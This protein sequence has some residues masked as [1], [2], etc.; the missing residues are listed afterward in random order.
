MKFYVKFLLILLSGVFLSLSFY[1]LGFLAWFCLVPCLLAIY[2]SSIKQTILFSWILGVVY[3]A[4]VTY[5]FVEYSFV[6][7][8]P[9]VGLLTIF[10]ML[11]G[12]V[13][14]FIYS[15][16]EWP[17]LRIFLIS[18]VWLAIEFLRCRTFLAFPW[19]M[20]GY[21]QH[22]FLPLMQM[23]RITGI[24]GVSL[25]LVLFNSMLAETIIY[26]LKN[27]KVNLKYLLS[28]VYLVILIVIP[29][30]INMN[31]YKKNFEFTR[32]SEAENEEC[33]AGDSDSKVTGSYAD[34]K[35]NSKINIAIVQTNIS[36]DD[37]YEKDSGVIIPDPYGD[38][39]YFKEGTELIV[40]PESVIWG[41]LERENN[42]TFKKW[43]S[44][45]IR[46]ENLYLIMGQILWDEQENYY[47]SVLLY[48]PD[49]EIIGRYNKIHPLPCGEYMPYPNILGFLDFLHVAKLDITPCRQ[50]SMIYY[51]GRGNLGTNICFESTLP[52]ISRSFRNRGADV[53][54][55]FTDDAAFKDSIAS[56]H[57][58]VFSKVRAIE[59]NCYVVHSSS[60]GI[61]GVVSPIGEIISKTQLGKTEV[62][63]ETIYLNSEKSFYSIFGNTA[64]YIYFGFSAIFLGVCVFRNLHLRSKE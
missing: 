63:Y 8:L 48:T 19:G 52:I 42:V 26:F 45:T 20:L 5:W 41:P 59:N 49:L 11:F 54:F 37:K 3:F 18:A 29:G 47:N 21:S 56:W 44:K 12:I 17:I 22:N 57:H 28:A 53:I 51:P 31:L 46:K 27:R 10:I 14:Y 62:L 33:M 50:F 38:K 16:I 13:L 64:M 23:A 60:M 15:K 55:V 36:F 39:N 30:L 1:E 25:I 35:D 32:S 9:I 7:W 4:G 40:F 61:S 24:Y 6:F 2:Y 43:V 58:L 34:R